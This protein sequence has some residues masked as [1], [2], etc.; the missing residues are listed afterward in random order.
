M[1]ILVYAKS[2]QKRGSIMNYEKAFIKI[3][4]AAGAALEQLT[5]AKVEAQEHTN[6]MAILTTAIADAES[7]LDLER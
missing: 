7:I 6:A 1:P 3:Y 4:G 2:K 5:A